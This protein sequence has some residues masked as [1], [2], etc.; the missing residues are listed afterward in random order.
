MKTMIPQI[1][2]IAFC[3]AGVVAIFMHLPPALLRWTEPLIEEGDAE[4]ALRI[5]ACWI[6]DSGALDH[7]EYR[8]E[9]A[10]FRLLRLHG[11]GLDHHA[12]AFLALVAA[13]R[14]EADPQAPW[15]AP[16][17]L[18]LSAASVRRAEILGAALRLAYTLSG[19][20]PSLLDATQLERR[21]QAGACFGLWN[22][23]AKLNLALAAGLALPLLALLGYTPGTADGL[24]ALSVAYAL[25]PL[26]FTLL[27]AVLLWRWRHS[28][29]IDR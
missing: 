7:P 22:F 16:A 17:R 14:Y 6:S 3:L 23:V 24:P 29:E 28:L 12:R 25:L 4:P 18:L 26:L 15:L 13:L 20:V 1:I 19:G 2:Y 8:A 9:Q 5:A 21:G 11:V 27:A 10:F